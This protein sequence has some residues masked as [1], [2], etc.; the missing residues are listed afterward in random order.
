MLYI[1]GKEWHSGAI[2]DASGSLFSYGIVCGQSYWWEQRNQRSQ[3]E[4][5]DGPV[6]SILR[7]SAHKQHREQAVDYKVNVDE[8]ILYLAP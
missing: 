7:R 3:Y 8:D 6:E 5:N 1:I 4:Q 2:V